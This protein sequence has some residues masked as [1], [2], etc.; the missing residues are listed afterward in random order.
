MKE[1]ILAIIFVSCTIGFIGIG[2]GL[3]FRAKAVK[4]IQLTI[5]VG[6]FTLVF[7]VPDAPL[8]FVIEDIIAVVG[9][10]GERL[11]ELSKEQPAIYFGI[12]ILLYSSAIYIGAKNSKK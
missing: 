5:L 10:V 1:I 6:I 2:A 8:H 4:A 7:V 12:I 11:Y 9:K 3:V